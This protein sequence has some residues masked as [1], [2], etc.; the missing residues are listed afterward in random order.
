MRALL[1]IQRH[2]SARAVVESLADK[3]PAID[4]ASDLVTFPLRILSGA[5]LFATA[6]GAGLGASAI[7]ELVAGG[8]IAGVVAALKLVLRPSANV[9]T[10]GVSA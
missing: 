4:T 3:V 5:A 1:I 2:L 6:T 8:G 7:P 10:A 9:A